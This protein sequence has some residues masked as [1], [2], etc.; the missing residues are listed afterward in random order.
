MIVVKNEGI[1][2][3]GEWKLLV[4][5]DVVKTAGIV[6]KYGTIVV[7]SEDIVVNKS[8]PFVN[9]SQQLVSSAN[10]LRSLKKLTSQNLQQNRIHFR[11]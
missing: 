9:S 4:E 1:V 5:L 6:V 11:N 7:K 2:V 10:Y 3:K 8:N